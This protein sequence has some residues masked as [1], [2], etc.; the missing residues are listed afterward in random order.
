M[1]IIGSVVVLSL[2]FSALSAFYSGVGAWKSNTGESGNYSAVA[3][4]ELV[5][6]N[7]IAINQTLTFSNDVLNFSVV[8]QKIDD[9][10][11]DV[12]N[13]QGEY[14]G[15]GYC[16]H[17]H[18]QNAKICHTVTHEQ[19]YIAESTIKKTEDAIYR[20]GSKTNLENS[21]KIIWKD[22]LF[23]QDNGQ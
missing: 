6:D 4:I 19:G 2:S 18:E 3:T 1:K 15:D 14:I 10:F 13:D 5:D 16:W 20:I 7:N 23:L 9:N 12:V 21:E 22:E 11:Y 8:L 17:N